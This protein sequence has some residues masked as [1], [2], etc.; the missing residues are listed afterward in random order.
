MFVLLFGVLGNHNLND[1][2]F[3][4]NDWWVDDYLTT[5]SY[6]LNP[7]SHWSMKSVEYVQWIS[8]VQNWSVD[9]FKY[10]AVSYYKN[11]VIHRFMIIILIYADNL[12]SLRVKSIHRIEL[13]LIS[14]C[15]NN[16]SP[17]WTSLDNLC[18]TFDYSPHVSSNSLNY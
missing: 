15:W 18:D 16:F 10:R 7:S 14:S 2:K 9:M 4:W 3:P 11:I 5:S 17:H 13:S 12:I 8:L 1:I 6:N